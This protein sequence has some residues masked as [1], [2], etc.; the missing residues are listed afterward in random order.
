MDLMK[1]NFCQFLYVSNWEV[2]A[3]LFYNRCPI[4]VSGVDPLR[5]CFCHALEQGWSG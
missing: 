5:T 3:G 2:R 4:P 1:I